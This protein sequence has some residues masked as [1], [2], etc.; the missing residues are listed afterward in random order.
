MRP[1]RREPERP[2]LYFRERELLSI[3]E[4]MRLTG[5]SRMTV[6]RVEKGGRFPKRRQIGK[7]SVRWL[8]EDIE[9]WMTSRPVAGAGVFGVSQTSLETSRK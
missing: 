4:V 6:Y 7:N 2:V 5:L 1:Q 3:Q 8:D 9:A